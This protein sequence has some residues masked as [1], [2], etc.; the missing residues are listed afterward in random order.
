MNNQEKTQEV[1]ERM[2]E[3]LRAGGEAD[4]AHLLLRIGAA[5]R[6]DQVAATSDLLKLFGG[7]GSLNDVVLYAAGQP[8]FDEN[9]EFGKLRSLLYD[10]CHR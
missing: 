8:Q 9:V 6:D 3:L 10:L 4:W 2:V 5:F 1:I 7:L